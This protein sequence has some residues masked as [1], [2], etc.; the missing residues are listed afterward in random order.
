MC[1]LPDGSLAPELARTLDGVG[2]WLEKFG[3]SIYGTRR[4]PIPPQPWG[5]STARGSPEHPAEIY[6]HILTSKEDVP[7]VFDPSIS[8]A[9]YLFGKKDPLK[10]T[11]SRGG[12]VLEL[13]PKDRLPIDTVITLMPRATEPTPKAN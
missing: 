9:P 10:L 13:P 2:Q 4:G 7:V 3:Q 1:A 6:L 12:L 5:F 11:R 8:W